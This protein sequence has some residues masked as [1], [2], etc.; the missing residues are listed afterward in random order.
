MGLPKNWTKYGCRMKKSAIIA[1][2][3]ALG[4]SVALP[5]AEYVMAGIAEVMELNLESLFMEL[6]NLFIEHGEVARQS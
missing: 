3:R 1:R 6:E 4:N 5:C 2:Y